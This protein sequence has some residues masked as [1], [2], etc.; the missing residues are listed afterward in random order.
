MNLAAEIRERNRENI[1]HVTVD[2]T[3]V[4]GEEAVKVVA[5]LHNG[6][7]VTGTFTKNAKP[8]FGGIE[9]KNKKDVVGLMTHK[10]NSVLRGTYEE[11]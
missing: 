10:I 11:G 4:R 7:Y 5:V 9:F 6:K 8:G 1:K 3:A 2:E